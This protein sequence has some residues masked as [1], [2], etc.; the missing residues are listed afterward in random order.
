MHRATI[1][2]GIILFCKIDA[3]EFVKECKARG[4]T[5][6]PAMEHGIDFTGVNYKRSNSVYDE[7]ILFLERKPDDLC[8][9]IVCNE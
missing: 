3:I 5:T 9:E 8:F 7:A 4:E 1:K 6:Q 2:G